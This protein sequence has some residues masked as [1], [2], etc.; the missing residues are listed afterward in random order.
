MLKFGYSEEATKFVASSEY[1]NFN[2]VKWY[3]FIWNE[4]TSAL[5]KEWESFEKSC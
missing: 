2:Q 3:Q 1:Q 4:V 5:V